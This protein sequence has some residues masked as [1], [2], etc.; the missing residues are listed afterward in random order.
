MPRRMTVGLVLLLVASASFAQRPLAFPG[1]EGFG[2]HALGG[3]GGKVLFVTNLDD[4]GPG[5]LRAAIDESGP[6]T[7][8]FRVGGTIVLK[9]PLTVRNPYVTIAGQT[10]PGD[11]ICLRDCEFSVDQTHD[12]VIRYLR[13]RTGNKAAKPADADAIS[14]YDSHDVIL[15]HCSA[16]WGTDECLS[17]TTNSRDI[18]VQWCLIAEGLLPHSMGSLILGEDGGQS[19][20]H[21]LYA[22][23][24]NRLPRFGGYMGHVGPLIDFRNNVI[25]D[26]GNGGGYTVA[27]ERY[28]ANYVG[29]YCKAGPASTSHAAYPFYYESSLANQGDG[30]ARVA[31]TLGA[32][33]VADNVLDGS[34]EATK[35]NWRM[36]RL[37]EGAPPS[38]GKYYWPF[39]VP[40]VATDPAPVAY[41]R[42]L[43]EVGAALPVRDAVD[44]RIIADVKAGTGKV[45]TSQDEVGG[46]PE[47][48]PGTPAPD[49]DNDGMPDA[50]ET[51]FGLKPNDAADNAQD[52]DDDGY[53]NLEECL[54]GTDPTHR[55]GLAL[56]A[57]TLYRYG[58]RFAL[59]AQQGDAIGVL[60]Q[61]RRLGT[62][63]EP[64][65]AK[66]LAPDHTRLL[67]RTVAADGEIK[68]RIAAPA[69][70]LYQLDVN[71]DRQTALVQ[72]DCPAAAI[73]ASE[74]RPLT[75]YSG[76][77]TP[78]LWLWV[79]RGTKEFSVRART[80]GGSTA[81]TLTQPDGKM[82]VALEGIYPSPGQISTIAVPAGQDGQ[83]W[84]VQFS[85]R[86]N[87]SSLSF[88]GL[89]PLLAQ[90]PRQAEQLATADLR[91]L[92]LDK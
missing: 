58:A 19:W 52:L 91:A 12:V 41:E 88:A 54:N 42:V 50:W 85:A 46:W 49:G 77:E 89:P 70:G 87:T 90:T 27:D 7:I 6:R 38:T 2:A 11:G 36:I 40:P 57:G 35:D 82:A 33:Y 16:T 83:A 22:H 64:E 55:D 45:L 10:A 61:P 9:S 20:H 34:P 47:Y 21:N 65:Q 81:L 18:T 37:P 30:S 68:E 1:A 31:T 66:L 24:N 13:S 84:A 63:P 25:Y 8:L 23:H 69:T 3:R 39:V 80:G 78:T 86:G 28:A 29:N 71:T 67:D 32:M 76:S 79:P 44:A 72:L 51:K 5:S 75:V 60:V 43:Q 56:A 17:V 73:V 74:Q 15:D 48:K 14:V 26:W 53:T 59:W 92:N 4:A 62:Y